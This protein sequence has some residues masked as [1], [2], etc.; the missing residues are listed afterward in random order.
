MR[1][2]GRLLCIAAGVS[3]AWFGLASVA[4]SQ[5]TPPSL[6][7]VVERYIA[8]RGGPAFAKGLPDWR[9]TSSVEAGGLK[10][11]VEVW[12]GGRG[13]KTV[14]DLGPLSSVSVTS[15]HGSWSMDAAGVVV[16]SPRGDTGDSPDPQS[17]DA[18]RGKGGPHCVLA[19]TEQLDGRSWAVARVSY[20]DGDIYDEFLD[21]ATGELGAQR[22]TVKGQARL[23][24]YSDWRM[25]DGVRLAFATRSDLPG[26][27]TLMV[28]LSTIEV[29]VAIDPGLFKPPKPSRPVTFAG[30]T[31][32]TAWIDLEP[33]P[34]GHIV[35]PVRIAGHT[36]H[37]EL[38]TGAGLSAI[39]PQAAAALGL[40]TAAGISAA[41]ATGGSTALGF[42]KSFPLT[43]DT[44]TFTHFRPSV[45]AEVGAPDQALFGEDV[46]NQA[47]VD[48]DFEH[49]RIRFLDPATFKAP[50]GAVNIP[51]TSAAG[52][53]M[54]PV[55][56]EGHKAAL[57][58]IDSGANGGVVAP[59][60]A[61]ILGAPGDRPAR[62]ATAVG[63]GGAKLLG[64]VANLRSIG[65]AGARLTDVP[66][67]F[68]STWSVDYYTSDMQGVIGV[69]MLRRFHFF[70]DWSHDRM[71]LILNP[72]AT[73]TAP[74][75]SSSR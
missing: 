41:G 63:V 38:D 48:I 75:P 37:V 73:P 44:L 50:K 28:R 1:R 58:Q 32:A 55:E 25:E 65:F 59:A 9:A 16:S 11:S 33:N 74:S 62:E 46:L 40:D 71:F 49:G 43:I 64:K 6:A 2:V 51:L 22:S 42:T 20:G 52:L 70:L 19:G 4:V 56:V 18:L 47:V 8:W 69:D 26:G 30:T 57:F 67:F 45:T 39:H 66:V 29:N 3:L 23:D 21:P 60:Y 14:L 15:P 34:L 72:A 24:H 68:P 7:T 35:F 10:G 31:H 53:R 36:L 54:A 13:S 5:T 27:N 17:S 12:N 61:A